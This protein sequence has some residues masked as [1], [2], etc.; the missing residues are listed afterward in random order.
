MSELLMAI[1]SAAG[2]LGILGF[3]FG[4]LLAFASKVFFVKEDERKEKILE[5]LPGANCG[6]CGFAG[7]GAFADALLSG[8]AA[9]NQCNA[10]GQESVDRI[11]EIVGVD[12]GAVVKRYA[13]IRCN[14]NFDVANTKYEYVGIA[15]CRA[16][17][18]L[19]GGQ[20]QCKYGC[21]G[22][23]TCVSACKYDA[24]KLE[25]GIASVVRERCTG[26]GECAKICP[27]KI[28][29]MIPEHAIYAVGCSSQEKGAITKK[30]C[31]TG[32]LGCKICVKVCEVGAISVNN[33]VAVI[34]Y[35]KCTGCGLCAQK[36]PVNII[37]R[38]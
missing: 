32:C 25:N 14:G 20:M 7:C 16:S 15:D 5:C 1:L 34:D 3:V 37:E 21:V 22:L 11:A 31:S 28:I 2:V 27:K 13:K 19:Q 23:G 38:I 4:L 18:R 35:D 36:C 26:C 12:A 8:E 10:T 24:I 6:G 33:N 9:P 17:N 30:E 29:D